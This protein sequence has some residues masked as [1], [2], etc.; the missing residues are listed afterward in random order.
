MC[1]RPGRLTP[2]ARATFMIAASSLA[3]SGCTSS[4]T[5]VAEPKKKR[6]LE[7]FAESIYGVK[8][9]PRVSNLES[10]LPR[11]GG[12]EQLGRPYKIKGQWYHPKEDPNYRSVGLASWYGDAFH[13]RLTANGEIYDMTHLTAAHPTMPLPSYAR[14]TNPANGASLVV[15]VNDRGPFHDGR[16]ID[17]SRRAAELLDYTHAGVAKVQVEYIGRAP[18]HGQD[19]AFLLASYNPGG[20]GPDPSDGLPTGVMIAMNGAT[21]SGAPSAAF[22]G[23]LSSSASAPAIA[24]DQVPLPE[25]GPALPSRPATGVAHAEWASPVLAYA[26]REGTA[27]TGAL[28]HLASG[29]G[30][31]S[32]HVLVGTFDTPAEAKAIAAVLGTAGRVDVETDV[33]TGLHVVRLMPDGT[34]QVDDVLRAAWAAGAHDAMTVRDE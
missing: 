1:S 9:S 5:D 32:E 15:R 23:Q 29:A 24:A 8:A 12:R 28:D 18:L 25:F 27:A 4:S 19:D 33:E 13:G 30:I 2:L 10:N 3:L 34:R 21:P 11:G 20:V 16:V 17:L 22:P 31:R 6:S 14:V 7:Y 26:P